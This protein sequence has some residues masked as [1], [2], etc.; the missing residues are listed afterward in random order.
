[1]KEKIIVAWS[2]GKDSAMALHELTN[3]GIFEITALIT[4]LTEDYERISMHGVRRVLLNEQASLLRLP[5]EEIRITKQGTNEEYEKKMAECLKKHKEK[6]VE[7][8]AFGDIFLEDLKKYRENNLAKISMRG[9][10]PLW[11]KDTLGLARSFIQAGFK[12][13]LTCVDG[14]KLSGEFAG[15]IFDEKL[16][17]DLPSD[18]DP[19]GENGEFHSFVFDGPILSLPVRFKKGKTVL[20]DNRFYYCDLFPDRCLPDL[21][22][23]ESLTA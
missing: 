12:S 4:T 22:G 6:G 17:S 8:V 7:S 9:L 11:G 18:V 21:R 20:R 14:K 1:M 23:Q 3:S 16:L 5:L 10:F 2:G 13:I 19:S 15:R